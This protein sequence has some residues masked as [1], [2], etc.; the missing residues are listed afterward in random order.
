MPHGRSQPS[1]RTRSR[2]GGTLC[3]PSRRGDRRVCRWRR[4]A[5]KHRFLSCRGSAIARQSIRS[6]SD[7]RNGAL[8][9][10]ALPRVAPSSSVPGPPGSR[11]AP[12]PALPPH[13]EL[14]STPYPNAGPL[15]GKTHGDAVSTN[16][17]GRAGSAV[18]PVAA[19]ELTQCSR[20]WLAP[21]AETGSTARYEDTDHSDGPEFRRWSAE[22]WDGI[23]RFL[24]R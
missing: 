13:G 20:G 5:W 6:L 14:P 8:R 21:I 2:P 4:K 17:V 23:G 12:S 1:R 16:N 7:N 9:R 15:V 18:T 19:F 11:A 22:V 3:D 24:G 10:R